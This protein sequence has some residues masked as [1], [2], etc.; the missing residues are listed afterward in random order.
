MATCCM[1][2]TYIGWIYD[3]VDQGSGTKLYF[4][5]DRKVYFADM[6]LRSYYD[7]LDEHVEGHEVD[8]REMRADRVLNSCLGS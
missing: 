3:F 7:D 4:G 5:I 2:G 1:F 6:E 8:L